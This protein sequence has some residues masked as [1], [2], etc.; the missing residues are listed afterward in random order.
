[1]SVTRAL[2]VVAA[3]ASV[4]VGFAGP[5]RADQMMVGIYTYTHGNVVAEYPLYCEP[6]SLGR[7]F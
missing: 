6:G 1:M 4:A 3:L 7:C 2:A 5:A